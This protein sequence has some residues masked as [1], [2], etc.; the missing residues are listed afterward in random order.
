[1][2]Q[3]GRGAR[4]RARLIAAALI[5][6]ALAPGDAV[7]RVAKF[8]ILSVE[9]PTFDGRSFGS[10]GAYERIVARATIAV[11]PTDRHNGAIV[12]LDLAPKNA[13]QDVEAFADVVILRPLDPT[14]GNGRIF[15][16][17]V[18]RG[19]KLGLVLMNDAP[20]T[21]MPAKA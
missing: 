3:R 12:D 10:V 7:A 6:A 20:P 16:D 13:S 2:R 11:V 4:Y 17:I 9:A 5:A 19:H 18:N 21:D 8:E 14:K 15:Y 1:M